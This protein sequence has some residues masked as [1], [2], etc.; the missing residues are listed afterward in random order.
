MQFSMAEP[1]TIGRPSRSMLLAGMPARTR[2]SERK[3]GGASPKSKRRVA[4]EAG[5][6][7]VHVAPPL[8]GT[9]LP[10]WRV[11]ETG[12]GP[13]PEMFGEPS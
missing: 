13:V 6:V 11:I 9:F 12:G 2:I 7:A 8:M 5:A 10:G 3:F 1:G 4:V